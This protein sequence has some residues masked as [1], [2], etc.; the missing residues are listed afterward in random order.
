MSI[1][2]L[3]S[4]LGCAALLLIGASSGWATILGDWGLSGQVYTNGTFGN[5]NIDTPR[6]ETGVT[7]NIVWAEGNDTVP[8]NPIF[9]PRP[10]GGEP[11]DLEFL[12]WRVNTS[13]GQ[14][15]VVGITSLDPATGHSGFHLGD[16][17]LDVDGSNPDPTSYMGYDYALSNGTWTSTHG[18]DILHL[19]DGD[20]THSAGVGIYAINGVADV[21]GITNDGGLGNN[22]IITSLSDPFAIRNGATQLGIAVT[23]TVE[24]IQN[25]NSTPN[26]A[27]QWTMDASQFAALL[28]TQPNGHPDYA[29]LMLH[30][31]VECGNDWI[32]TTPTGFHE[33]VVPEPATLMLLGLGLATMGVVRRR[34][35]TA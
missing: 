33:P 34:S 10:S 16:V 29:N 19:G 4:S 28:P 25:D 3:L 30:W 5:W 20:Y 11:Y 27:V 8:P 6:T 12:A 13:L 31:T 2:R 35:R 17:F 32:E 23:R 21:H 7:N 24:Q 14:F 15:Q 22:A 1:R 9:G 18:H 26:W